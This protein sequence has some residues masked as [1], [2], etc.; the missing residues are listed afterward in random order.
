MKDFQKFI[1]LGK[2]VMCWVAL[3]AGIG[4]VVNHFIKPIEYDLVF[5]INLFCFAAVL[6]DSDKK[7]NEHQESK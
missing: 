4:L 3:F 2:K 7:N 1:P 6:G 5:A